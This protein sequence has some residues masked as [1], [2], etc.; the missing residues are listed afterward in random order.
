[1]E[2]SPSFDLEIY[3][4]RFTEDLNRHAAALHRRDVEMFMSSTSQQ[5]LRS[6][7]R[8]TQSGMIRASAPT[9]VPP[10]NW[11]PAMTAPPGALPN[12]ININIAAPNN[13]VKMETDKHDYPQRQT[14]FHAHHQP[15]NTGN[16]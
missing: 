6:V 4:Q 8:P 5:P 2:N 16:I 15:L 7:F 12:K 9:S 11:N 10:F 13:T 3:V 14:N 1:M